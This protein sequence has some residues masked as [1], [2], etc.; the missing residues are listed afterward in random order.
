MPN[1]D[2]TK[3]LA[4]AAWEMDVQLTRDAATRELTDGRA[5]L[6]SI[7]AGVQAVADDGTTTADA[8][9]MNGS[10]LRR[11]NAA[12]SEATRLVAE[13]GSLL[14]HRPRLDEEN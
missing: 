3:P 1:F 7:I 2:P 10:D 6:D 14:A 8:S 13:L 11:L 4:L 5:V 12:V 9:T